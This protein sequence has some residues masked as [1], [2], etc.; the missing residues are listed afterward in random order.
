MV[1]MH[2]RILTGLALAACI[3][4][5]CFAQG[6]AA[7]ACLKDLEALPDFLLENDTGARDRLAL[8]GQ[9]YFDDTL[10][11]AKNAALQ[12]R[13][14]AS[15]TPVIVK[16]LRTWRRGHLGVEEITAA[17]ATAAPRQSAEDA[18]ARRL[19]SAPTLEVL[20]TKTLRLTLKSFEP[21]K[22][23]ALVAL[24]KARREGLEAH[25]NWIIDVLGNGGGNDSSYEPLIPWLM[26]DGVAV[27]SNAILAHRP[28]SRAGHAS[29]R[30]ILPARRSA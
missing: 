26:P 27:A 23:D 19:K 5:N 6:P 22:R 10:A 13:G 4:L 9:K 7:V 2:G 12:I 25:P 21:Y 28:I 3:S 18:A 30:L 20:S 11:E 8:S 15:C 16:N 1:S 29:A 14:N 24:I 17:P